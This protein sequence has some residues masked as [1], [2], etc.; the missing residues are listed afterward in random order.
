MKKITLFLVAF[1]SLMLFAFVGKAQTLTTVN[2]FSTDFPD[3]VV[4]SPATYPTG[5]ATAQLKI[6]DIDS[7]P[8][9]I[10][11]D[12]GT[13]TISNLVTSFPTNSPVWKQVNVTV[14]GGGWIGN[15]TLQYGQNHMVSVRVDWTWNH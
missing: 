1:C 12:V 4:T 13:T 14:Y 7:H 5:N 9:F 11:V 8:G 10:I 2:V 6:K 3:E 15:V